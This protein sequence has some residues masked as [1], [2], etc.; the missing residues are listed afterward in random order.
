V[1]VAAPRTLGYYRRRRPSCLRLRRLDPRELTTAAPS[2]SRRPSLNPTTCGTPYL[3][4]L[5]LRLL[6]LLLKAAE[7]TRATAATGVAQWWCCLPRCFQA[8]D[9]GVGG[10]WGRCQRTTKVRLVV[11]GRVLRLVWLVLNLATPTT[12][13]PFSTCQ[14][15]ARPQRSR[16]VNLPTWLAVALAAKGTTTGPSRRGF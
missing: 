2:T 8:G 9:C 7:C 4:G 11:G 13:A 5:L 3:G 16:R 12:A 14:S 6:L 1:V 10:G 15:S